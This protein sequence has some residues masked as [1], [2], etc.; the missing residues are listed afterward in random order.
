MSLTQ[1][2]N[3]RSVAVVGAST[4]PGAVGHI[5][6]QNLL[7]EHFPGK[8]FPVNPKTDTLLGVPCYPSLSAIHQSIDL[9][10]IV[11]PAAIVPHVAT[12]LRSWATTF[13]PT[14]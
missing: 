6:V 10:L 7:G 4:T 13:K 3:P 12:M 1:L 5:I 2:F 11:V 8:V 14:E 9:A